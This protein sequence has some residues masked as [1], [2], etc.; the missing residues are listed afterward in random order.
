MRRS[1]HGDRE[2]RMIAAYAGRAPQLDPSVFVVNSATVIG[3]VVIGPESSIWFGAVVRGD[4]E[5]IRIGARSNVQ[6][7][8]TLHVVGGKFGTT[9]GD[10]VTVGHNAIVH[11][12]IVEDGALI[13]MVAIVLDGAV[14]GTESLVGAGTLVA[15]GTR[16][17]PR[18][19]V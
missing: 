12:C 19:L 3:D 4:I 6:D 9:L 13:G 1:A 11:G 17:P 8:A 7:N 2:G 16:I 10:G 5:S 14:I 18:S 15:P